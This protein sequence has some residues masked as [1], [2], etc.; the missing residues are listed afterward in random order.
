MLK[1]DAHFVH[2]STRCLYFLVVCKPCLVFSS[3]AGWGEQV[4][5]AS[6]ERSSPA[7]PLRPREQGFLTFRHFQVSLPGHFLPLELGTM[8]PLSYLSSQRTNSFLMSPKSQMAKELPKGGNCRGKQGKPT[9]P[10]PWGAQHPPVCAAPH[11]V[12]S[13]QSCAMDFPLSWHLCFSSQ[14][15]GPLLSKFHSFT[16]QGKVFCCPQ[17]L[18]DPCRCCCSDAH[19]LTHSS[20]L[21]AHFQVPRPISPSLMANTV[22]EEKNPIFPTRLCSL[23]VLWALGRAELTEFPPQALHPGR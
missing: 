1:K 3:S 16:A 6:P 22:C 23:T 12:S 5:G 15:L 18:A 2:P 21:P 19:S 14:A 10:K 8:E 11:S 17:T 7:A 13:A 9:I 4:P 20:A